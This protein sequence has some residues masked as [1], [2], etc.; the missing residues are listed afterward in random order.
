MSGRLCA[1]NY[2]PIVLYVQLEL[3]AIYV[4]V[5]D[6]LRINSV[7]MRYVDLVYCFVWRRGVQLVAPIADV[8]LP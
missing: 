6:G 2:R 4:T 7:P 3:L 8:L 5:E 1:Y